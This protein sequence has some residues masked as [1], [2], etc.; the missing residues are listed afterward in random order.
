MVRV[1]ESLGGVQVVAHT[2]SA[3]EGIA[4][5]VDYQPDLVILDADITEQEPTDVVR[6]VKGSLEAGRVLLLSDRATHAHVERALAAGADGF[7]LKDV[8]V[9][10][11]SDTVRRMCEGETVL[12]PAAASALAQSYAALAQGKRQAV[13]LTPRQREILRLL[14]LGLENKQIARRLGIGVHTVKTHVSRVLHKL[15]V[16]SRTEA[17]VIALRD[18]LIT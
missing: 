5:A 13:P 11:F 6:K 8:S 15:G 2:G 16:S 12:H 18:R 4:F 3:D 7:T 14:A 1:L 10:D 9:A 17:V